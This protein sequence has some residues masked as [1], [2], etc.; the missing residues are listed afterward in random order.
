LPILSVA[1]VASSAETVGTALTLRAFREFGHTFQNLQ[2]VFDDDRRHA[3]QIAGSL[4]RDSL[5]L[6]GLLTR[7]GQSESDGKSG[8]F[9]WP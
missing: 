4:G 8:A 1:S 9:A 5:D 2:I 6:R 7:L 3:S